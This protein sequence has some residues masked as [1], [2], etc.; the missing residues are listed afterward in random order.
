MRTFPFR[1]MRV[2]AA[3]ETANYVGSDLGNNT[4]DVI[5]PIVVDGNHQGTA[6]KF[7]IFI[8]GVV[9]DDGLLTKTLS[10]G[11]YPE[12]GWSELVHFYKTGTSGADCHRI[13]IWQGSLRICYYQ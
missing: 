8:G 10:L 3:G 1:A 12:S 6:L 4:W 5:M 13:S 7:N 11:S 2:R 9:F